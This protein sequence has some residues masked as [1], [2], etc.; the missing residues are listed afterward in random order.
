MANVHW[1]DIHRLR[2][3]VSV[4]TLIDDKIVFISLALIILR[5]C[6]HFG[7][8]SLACVCVDI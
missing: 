4:L 3:H 7:I 6:V 2:A 8:D 5:A 1:F